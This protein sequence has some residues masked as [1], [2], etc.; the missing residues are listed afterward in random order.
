MTV[1]CNVIQKEIY[2]QLTI[3]L[4]FQS[5]KEEVDAVLLLFSFTDRTSFDDLA[6][7]IAKWTGP[8]G[9]QVV[10]VV[11][12][13]KYPFIRVCNTCRIN[14]LEVLNQI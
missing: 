5:C 10:M 4:I 9:E 3:L 7:Q 12:G 6:N 2:L 13:T 8:S 1:C 14:T 11:V